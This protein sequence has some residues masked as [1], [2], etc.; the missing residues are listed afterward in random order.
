MRCWNADLSVEVAVAGVTVNSVAPGWIATGS[1]LPEEATAG[2]YT[3]IGRSGTPEEVAEV[4]AFLASDRATY[5]TGTVIVQLTDVSVDQQPL[6]VGPACQTQATMDVSEV[7]GYYAQNTPTIP[8]VQ[9]KPGEWLPLANITSYISAG[10]IDLPAFTGCHHGSG[11]HGTRNIEVA[12]GAHVD[13][14]DLDAV[15]NIVS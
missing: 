6:D 8:P 3:P 12:A 7:P 13:I 9:H 5:V 15:Q 11:L 14:G 2:L 1:Q 10:H 4:V